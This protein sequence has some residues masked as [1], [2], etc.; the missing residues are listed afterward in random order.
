MYWWILRTGVYCVLVDIV[1]WWILRTGGYC[2]LVDIVYWHRNESLD[3]KFANWKSSSLQS[4]YAQEITEKNQDLFS[5]QNILFFLKLLN[6][7]FNDNLLK[8]VHLNIS[9]TKNYRR[10]LTTKSNTVKSL[11]V[12]YIKSPINL[13]TQIRRPAPLSMWTHSI[14]GSRLWLEFGSVRVMPK[15]TC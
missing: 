13:Q 10:N 9:A 14:H 12:S 4:H 1:Y 5:P 3:R 8:F 7:S 6:S 15:L 2:V 11:S